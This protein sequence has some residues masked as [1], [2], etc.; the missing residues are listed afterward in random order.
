MKPFLYEIED[1][2]SDED[3]L[4]ATPVLVSIRTYVGQ[5]KFKKFRLWKF[6]IYRF[7]HFLTMLIA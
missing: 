5:Y 7:E 1:Q 2:E 6:I 4:S 3:E